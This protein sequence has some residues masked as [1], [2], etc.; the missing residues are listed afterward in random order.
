V[1][2]IE[3]VSAFASLAPQDRARLAGWLQTR[4]F[5][6]GQTILRR[7]Q[8]GG[9]LFVVS[10]GLA[11]AQT[12]DGQQAPLGPGDVFGEISAMFQLPVTATVRAH[13]ETIVA[14]LEQSELERALRELPGLDSALVELGHTRRLV[15]R[16]RARVAFLLEAEHGVA[17]AERLRDVTSQITNGSVEVYDAS[18]QPATQAREYVASHRAS[19]TGLLLVSLTP[20]ELESCASWIERGDAVLHM[21]SKGYV[22]SDLTRSIGRLGLGDH[23]FALI[24]GSED[25]RAETEDRWHFR[26][27]RA[28]F[29]N[30]SGSLSDTPGLA[31][32]ARWMTRRRVGLALSAGAARGFAHLG[33]LAVLEEAGVPIDIICGTS[34]GGIVGLLYGMSG[35]AKGA[36]ELC[37]QTIGRNDLVRQRSWFPRSSFMSGRALRERAW[38]ISD[39]RSFADLHARVAVVTCDLVHGERFVLDRGHVAPALLAT[40]AI[41]GALPPIEHK[42]RLLVDGALVNRIPIE[43]LD[44]ERCGLRIAV[45]VLPPPVDADENRS[46][47]TWRARFQRFLGLRSVIGRSWD[48]LSWWKGANDAEGADVLIE[49]DTGKR[50]GFDFNSI[51]HM[52]AAGRA[53]AEAQ[54]PRIQRAIAAWDEGTDQ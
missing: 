42:D 32:I 7:G 39:G 36:L 1:I 43:L 46:L 50:S 17:I 51:Q 30:E 45:N 6:P 29:T 53:A 9:E 25:E 35:T 33:V 49:P 40:S 48:V 38:R 19:G 12:A 16:Q 15:D 18:R 3:N 24:T 23:G 52:V 41:P 22:S 11:L 54:L 21:R 26:V 13:R 20:G 2:N 47:E 37:E 44:G 34:I 14:V 31:R 27:P 10:S 8:A 5:S 4:R 28:E